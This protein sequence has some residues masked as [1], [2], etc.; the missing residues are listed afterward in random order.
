MGRGKKHKKRT[1]RTESEGKW[2]SKEQ[3]TERERDKDKGSGRDAQEGST[4]REGK[5]RVEG[6]GGDAIK[7]SNVLE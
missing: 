6:K 4:G 2:G 1:N 7:R 5:R 3:E